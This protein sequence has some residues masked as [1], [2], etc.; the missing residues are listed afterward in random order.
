MSNKT[1]NPHRRMHLE[2]NN[3]GFATISYFCEDEQKRVTR[4]FFVAFP[5]GYVWEY[6][7]DRSTVQ[8]CERLA[9]T[10]STLMSSPLYLGKHI[11]REWTKRQRAEKK[12]SV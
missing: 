3:S 11:R 4:E 6:M 7:N 9:H 5:S 2:A 1:T 8:V 12:R 10:G